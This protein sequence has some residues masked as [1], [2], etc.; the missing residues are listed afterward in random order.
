[1]KKYLSKALFPALFVFAGAMPIPAFSADAVATNDV[2][3]SS[4]STNM[5]I[6]RQKVKADKKLVVAA[7]MK[8][9]DA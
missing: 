9:T 6:L 5:E 3:A 1:M 8:F 2:N 4:S 7:N